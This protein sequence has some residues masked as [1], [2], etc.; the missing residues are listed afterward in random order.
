MFLDKFSITDKKQLFDNVTRFYADL[1]K[2]KT[3]VEFDMHNL[4]LKMIEPSQ[5]FSLNFLEDNKVDGDIMMK[6]IITKVEQDELNVS[7][8]GLLMTLK[9]HDI[10]KH[11]FKIDET[12]SC[13]LNIL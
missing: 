3:T 9:N 8:G 12:I 1:D 5:Q 6:G 11:N 4:F 2:S 7:F 13:I 10:K